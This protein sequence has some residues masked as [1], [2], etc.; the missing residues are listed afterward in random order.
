MED[1][2]RRAGVSKVTVSRT[3]HCSEKVAVRTRRRV[4]RA[5][6]AAGYVKNLV[7]GSLASN[8]TNVIAAI[9]PTLT[10]A[11]Y[12]MSVHA[13]AEVLRQNGFHLLLGTVAFSPAE[14]ESLIATFLGRRPDAMYLHAC[15][16][17][18]A[19]KR[20]LR[21]AGIPVVEAGDLI[22]HPIDMVV[23]YSNFEAAKAATAYLLAKGYRR[24]A[25]VS[26][27]KRENDRHFNRWR[28]YRDALRENEIPY[29]P[30]LVVEEPFGF[31]FGA[32]ALLTI[33]KRAPNVQAVLFASD[34]WAVGALL[35][36]SRRGWSV[37]GKVA[38]VGFGDQE[39]AKEV[40][41]P[42]TTVRLPFEEVGRVAGQKLLE[43]L[44]GHSV[45]PKIVDLGFK[46]IGRASA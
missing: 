28:G 37:P 43:R 40:V 7:A 35:E 29:D 12:G 45:K 21:N 1:V 4:L 36:C 26:A 6:D 31:H 24:I 23:S 3:L 46:I 25:F 2:A 19:A 39:I 41:P 34:L 27:F 42:L 14:E 17:T 32:E 10:N 15:R 9:V 44:Q 11:A 16:H 33:V 38:I 5:I 30:A 18:P 13:M 20:L 22:R 8:R